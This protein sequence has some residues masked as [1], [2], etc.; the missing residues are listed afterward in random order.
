[1][2]THL[3]RYA[4]GLKLQRIKVQ[5]ARSSKTS[6]AVASGQAHTCN[7]P[8]VSADT[9]ITW[10]S[11]MHKGGFCRSSENNCAPV[12]PS[13]ENLAHKI[14][15]H[16]STMGTPLFG[17]DCHSPYSHTQGLKGNWFPLTPLA[18]PC[19]DCDSRVVWRALATCLTHWAVSKLE[20]K[21]G[22]SGRRSHLPAIVA[23]GGEAAL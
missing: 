5:R 14:F 4:I 15:P 19:S 1:M 8:L 18:W 16:N 17:L 3:P 12:H 23:V 10:A 6:A 20:K 11:Y 13:F 7:W 22:D 2:S 9:V 21:D